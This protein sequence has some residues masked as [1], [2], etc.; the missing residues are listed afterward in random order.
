MADANLQ[1]RKWLI[2]IIQKFIPSLFSPME[3]FSSFLFSCQL[4]YAKIVSCKL[5]AQGYGSVAP[6][7]GQTRLNSD[8]KLK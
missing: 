1:D 3:L 4:Q 7:E 2:V 6:S 5:Q 8:N